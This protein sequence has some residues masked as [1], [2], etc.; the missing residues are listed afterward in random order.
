MSENEQVFWNSGGPEYCTSNSR[1]YRSGGSVYLEVEDYDHEDS[2]RYDYRAVLAWEEYVGMIKKLQNGESGSLKGSDGASSVYFMDKGKGKVELT[3]Y[4]TP[5]PCTSP[6][7]TQVGGALII[8]MKL[9][10][11]LPK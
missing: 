11:L 9:D 7:G 10:M 8:P 3:L 6:G 1:M 4:G 5:S 2:R